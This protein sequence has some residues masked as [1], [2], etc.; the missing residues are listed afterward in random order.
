MGI[1]SSLY[2]GISGLNVNS[3]ATSVVAN[4]LAN[5][6]TVGFKSSYT[7]FEDV[8][9]SAIT[10]GSGGDQVGN[11]AGVA[12]VNT[13]YTQGSYEDSSTSTNVAINGDGYFIVIDPDTSSTYYTR[14]GNFDFDKD[15]N[16]VDPYGNSVQGWEVTNG[17]A[18]GSLTDIVLD[19][20]QSPPNATSDVSLS[21]NL[22]SQSTDNAVT[23]NPYTSEF[24]LY[25]GTESPPL[26]DSRYSYSSTMTIYD[27][28]GS[29]HDLTT[30][31]DPV[32]VDSDGN[33][34]WEYIISCD[35]EDDLRTFNGT[36]MNTTSG[37]GMLMTGTITFN[38]EGQMT[39]MSSF[40][41]TDSPVSSNAK[42]ASN[43][44]L[45]SFSDSGV[46]EMNVNFTGSADGQDIAF[47]FGMS[48]T[49]ADVGSNGGWST[50]SS[51][52]TLAD[53]TATTDY[54]D[55]PSFEG[56]ELST[57]ATTSYSDSS[58]ATYSASQDGYA[59]GSLLSVD[60]DEN[61]IISGNYSNSQTIELYQIALA[62]FTNPNG[63]VANGSNLFNA[64]T[65]SGEAIIGTAGS[66]GFGSVVSNSLE[67]SNVDLASEMTKLIIIQA[68]Y[69]ANSKVVTTADTLLQTAIGLKR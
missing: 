42:D 69:Q 7:T 56:T 62:D 17:T 63:L 44:E 58:S 13:D 59:T 10:T 66:A 38:S 54:S 3:Q 34:V 6:S 19:Q 5:S 9:Y 16:L 45:A 11:G 26:D 12:T 65:D 53:I 27:E 31:L 32:S 57:G 22:D 14:A 20:S 18:S 37:A 41:L 39:S 50:G 60:V 2:T 30:Y 28:N 55:L 48:N 1:T 15:G 33:I 21:M 46:P 24:D 68:A 43:W 64:T 52:S 36:D 67:A 25:D 40:T 35:P 23:S 4:N 29:S 8:F 61:G 51:I 49:G 47:S